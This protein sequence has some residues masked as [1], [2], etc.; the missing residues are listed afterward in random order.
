[1]RDVRQPRTPVQ[2]FNKKTGLSIEIGIPLMIQSSDVGQIQFFRMTD[3]E[4]LKVH[5]HR[6]VRMKTREDGCWR[7]LPLKQS[8]CETLN[9]SE[10]QTG[11]EKRSPN[12]T[13]RVS[14][15]DTRKQSLRKKARHRIPCALDRQ[16]QRIDKKGVRPVLYQRSRERSKA[17]VFTNPSL[18]LRCKSQ[19]ETHDL[20]PGYRTKR[21]QQGERKMRARAITCQSWFLLLARGNDPPLLRAHVDRQRRH[22]HNSPSLS[23]RIWHLTRVPS[24]LDL[25]KARCSGRAGRATDSW[26]Q[27]EFIID[28][29][30]RCREIRVQARQIYSNSNERQEEIFSWLKRKLLT[31]CDSIERTS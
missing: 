13:Q 21:D 24:P 15:M 9:E 31:E 8:D 25:E 22:N 3:G 4:G 5:G 12:E 30:N 10:D 26:L 23:G 18:F 17:L 20:L 1:M 2:M 11:A 7:V 28:Q 19:K 6:H 14:S 29:W 16:R 27:R